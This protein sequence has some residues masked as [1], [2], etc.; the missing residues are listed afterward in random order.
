[1]KAEEAPLINRKTISSKFKCEKGTLCAFNRTITVGTCDFFFFSSFHT[2]LARNG[3][4]PKSR[5]FCKDNIAVA[6]MRPR[7]K[8]TVCHLSRPVTL[9]LSSVHSFLLLN[10]GIPQRATSWEA[11]KW[12]SLVPLVIA[13]SAANAARPW[14]VMVLEPRPLGR[15]DYFKSHTRWARLFQSFTLF[16]S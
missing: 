2:Q 1:M 4:H 15:P 13:P 16:Y 9:L 6:Q 5:R 11:N 3:V 8:K 12:N 7:K 10:A 14:S